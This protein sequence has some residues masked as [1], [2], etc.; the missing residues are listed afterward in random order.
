MDFFID[1]DDGWAPP[2]LDPTE[3]EPHDLPLHHFHFFLVPRIIVSNNSNA[4]QWPLGNVSAGNTSQY[5]FYAQQAFRREVHLTIHGDITEETYQF[6]ASSGL[7]P[8]MTPDEIR[9]ALEENGESFY[10]DTPDHAA[11]A[12]AY[13]EG[14]GALSEREYQRLEFL[15]WQLAHGLRDE[16]SD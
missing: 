7:F 11:D 12:A 14:D 1:D 16:F 5:N 8:G 4:F 10:P 15:Q 9:Q 13:N 6:L 3:T 2:A